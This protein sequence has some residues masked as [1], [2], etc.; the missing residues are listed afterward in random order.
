MPDYGCNIYTHS[1]AVHHVLTN[2]FGLLRLTRTHTP[3]QYSAGAQ[4][5]EYVVEF[6][7]APPW[8]SPNVSSS[9]AATAARTQCEV[10]VNS[11]EP[12]YSTLVCVCVSVCA[13]VRACVC[14]HVC[15]TPHHFANDTT[16]K[17]S[18]FGRT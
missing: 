12:I 8:L 11:E 5:H 10:G 2:S 4:K 16:K 3:I 6:S 18:V 13:W 15:A 9:S 1:V 14:T 7:A 17:G